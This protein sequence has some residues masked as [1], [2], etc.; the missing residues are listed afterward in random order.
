MEYVW[1]GD[2]VLLCVA[3]LPGDW[4]SQSENICYSKCQ[5][6]LT[7]SRCSTRFKEIQEIR[8]DLRNFTEIWKSGPSLPQI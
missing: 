4:S 6:D 3:L 5:L 8:T 7:N 2:L 1:I